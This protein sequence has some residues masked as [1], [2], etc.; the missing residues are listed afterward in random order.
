RAPSFIVDVQSTCDGVE[1]APG[2]S[3]T[4]NVTFRP[5]ATG[6]IDA[7]LAIG[8]IHVSLGGE[9]VPPGAL[10]IAPTGK[11]FGQV[12]QGATSAAPPST[13]R[14]GG[15]AATGALAVALTGSGAA[16]FAI[17]DDGCSGKPLAAM[18]TCTVSVS[19]KPG[20]VGTQNASLA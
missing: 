7:T 15:G 5:D 13:V 18:A 8:D 14:N 4:V 20:A 3:C 10:V 11:D 9:G 12:V 2:A 6:Q 16:Q 17:S 1:L 19:F